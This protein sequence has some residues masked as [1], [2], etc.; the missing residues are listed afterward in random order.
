MYLSNSLELNVTY[1]SYL[2]TKV[3]SHV[4][5]YFFW[6]STY[7][8]KSAGGLQSLPVSGHAVF[9]IGSVV[10]SLLGLRLFDAFDKEEEGEFK[11]SV[12][13]EQ[14]KPKGSAG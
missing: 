4:I 3:F 14:G 2:A 13:V 7:K 10:I 5:Y 8:D 12:V 9:G 11:V 1:P 6:K